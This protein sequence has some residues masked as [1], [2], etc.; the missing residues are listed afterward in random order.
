[1]VPDSEMWGRQKAQQLV[2]SF[3]LR[4]KTALQFLPPL[5]VVSRWNTVLL[6]CSW[7]FCVT[8]SLP[9][10]QGTKMSYCQRYLPQ[11]VATGLLIAVGQAGAIPA[12]PWVS[13]A[14]WIS[15]K[16]YSHFPR[17]DTHPCTLSLEVW[18]CRMHTAKGFFHPFR[19]FFPPSSPGHLLP[20]LASTAEWT[21]TLVSTFGYQEFAASKV[22]K[23]A[24][25]A[26]DLWQK[27]VAVNGNWEHFF[28]SLEW[29]QVLRFA[30]VFQLHCI[31]CILKAL[32]SLQPL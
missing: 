19:T 24:D 16:L 3:H 27:G 12:V 15:L 28:T 14:S 23:A 18:R 26:G 29:A 8:S 4:K 5:P 10:Q 22:P 13:D 32:W 7:I 25:S 21:S 1:M 20:W 31:W 6:L 30:L 11:H 2:F 9:L 17:S